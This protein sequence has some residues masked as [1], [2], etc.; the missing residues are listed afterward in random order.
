MK[1]RKVL[2]MRKLLAVLLAAIMLV[3]ALAALPVG[4]A[5]TAGVSEFDNTSA[6]DETPK[7]LITEILIDSKTGDDT[8]DDQVKEGD[9]ATWFSPDAFD[10]IEIY[11]PSNEPV[12]L[13]DYAI[14]RSQDR[15]FFATP[16]KSVTA[17]QFT[18]HVALGN[19]ALTNH[20]D[21]PGAG[22]NAIR[23]HVAN[24]E[25]AVLK[26][27]EFAVI[28]FYGAD[29]MKLT[30]KVGM[31]GADDFRRHYSMPENTMV[32][33]VPAI[34]GNGTAFDLAPNYTYALV[35]KS[36][37]FAGKAVEDPWTPYASLNEKV[38]CMFDYILKNAVGIYSSAN[39]DDM[40]A[41][42]VPANC[43]PEA[44]NAVNWKACVTDEE[45]AA[46]VELNDYVEA[47][48][49]QTYRSGAILSY[50]EVPT[51]GTMPAW[52]WAYVDPVGETVTT[53]DG[54]FT[55]GLQAL[56]EAAEGDGYESIMAA[57][58]SDWDTNTLIKKDGKLDVTVTDGKV[59]W[60]TACVNALVTEK[61]DAITGEGN[62]QE[63]KIDYSK[64]FV[65]RDEL[66][67]RH[68]LKDKGKKEEKGMPIWALI[69]IIVGGVVLVAGIAVVVIIIIKK[70]NRP[71]AADDVAAEGEI[72]VVDETQANETEA[73]ADQTEE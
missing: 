57:L 10:Y 8:L 19:Y 49:T 73:P 11:N 59:A 18:G 21:A 41:Y 28:W 50:A 33:A 26:P 60:S 68:N 20:P 2:T 4:A 25:F 61:A 45:K 38:V 48:Y 66:E 46:Y 53:F 71:V 22:F 43:K 7:L 69:L 36:F 72:Q 15:N 9:V 52:Q 54:E 55:H 42:Y 29:T 32:I 16:D 6:A 17:A 30:E 3:G 24:P 44:L 23:D 31:I 70:K 1:K 58:V 5:A 37:N 13:Y 40:A 14:A 62:S 12:D 63:D 39:M 65:S 47:Q 67:K 56:S 35:E 34:K 27:G 51:P 64:N